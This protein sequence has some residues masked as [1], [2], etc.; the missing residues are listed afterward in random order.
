MTPEGFDEC[1]EELVAELTID[2]VSVP[3]YIKYTGMGWYI[4]IAKLNNNLYHWGY[5]GGSSAIDA[6]VS[7]AEWHA[8]NLAN[9]DAKTLEECVDCV[10]SVG[11]SRP[12]NLHDLSG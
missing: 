3:V 11:V 2:G 8:L 7:Y 6:E 4:V 12:Q 10:K 1:P 5:L 9:I